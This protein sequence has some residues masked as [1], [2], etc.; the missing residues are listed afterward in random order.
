MCVSLYII[1]FT[2]IH[3]SLYTTADKRVILI[4]FHHLAQHNSRIRTPTK[5]RLQDRSI[6]DSTEAIVDVVFWNGNLYDCEAN[7]KVSAELNTIFKNH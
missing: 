2:Y 6:V 1:S 7:T 3:S 5:D 4:I